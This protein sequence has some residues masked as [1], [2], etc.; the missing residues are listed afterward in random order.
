MTL[1][2]HQVSYRMLLH[3]RPVWIYTFDGWRVTRPCALPPPYSWL[4]NA[5]PSP[6]SR[7]NQRNASWMTMLNAS[8]KWHATTPTWNWCASGSR[9]TCWLSAAAFVS[10]LDG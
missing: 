5:P 3:S 10:H 8:P 1:D 9:G 4:S 2:Y 7:Q 6:S